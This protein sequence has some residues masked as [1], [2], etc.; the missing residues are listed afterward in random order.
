MRRSYPS[1]SDQASGLRRIFPRRLVRWSLVVQPPIRTSGQ[2]D[3]IAQRARQIAQ[4]MGPAGATPTL[5]IDAARSQVAHAFGL[6]ARF[7]LDHAI[8]GDCALGDVVLAAP[9]PSLWVLPAARA[10]DRACAE[11]TQTARVVAAIESVV[12]SVE[13]IVLTLSPTRLAFL[14][15]NVELASLRRAWIPM[16]AS[17]DAATAAL[18]AIRQTMSETGITAFGLL[19]SGMGGAAAA[20]LLSGTAAIARRHFGAAVSASG[21]VADL[22]LA[23][24]P[25]QYVA[26]YVAQYVPQ[27]AEQ[28]AEQ[29]ARARMPVGEIVN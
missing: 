20:R 17:P 1:I 9:L 16:D 26:Q 29:Y 11:E 18:A 21:S 8:E 3:A 6:K 4:W 15:C 27:D 23:A 24:P 10:V 14:R 19:F 13:H 2:A 25:P 12:A 22:E 28:C 7:D 5:V